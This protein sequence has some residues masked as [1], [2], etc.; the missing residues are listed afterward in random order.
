MKLTVYSKTVCPYCAQAKNYLKN[1]NIDF[2]E[3]NIEESIDA[4]NFVRSAG[5]RT[6][7]QIYYQDRIFVDEG[8]QGLS[9]MSKE[10]I[11]RE[12]EHRNEISNSNAVL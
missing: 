6:V 10:D 1:N 11:Q 8:W 5:H 12:I 3:I 2:E 4:M 9:K 7:P